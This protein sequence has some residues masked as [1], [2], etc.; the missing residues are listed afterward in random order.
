MARTL[1]SSRGWMQIGTD[2]VSEAI[3]GLDEQEF[4]AESSLPGWN[5]THLVAHLAANADAIGNLIHWAATGEP[6]PMYPSPEARALDIESGS[7]KSGSDLITW[8]QSATSRLEA[9]MSGLTIEEWAHEVVTAQGRTVPASETPWMRSREV[10]V[11]AVDLNVGIDF[12]QLPTDFLAALCQDIVIK[13]T[14][15]AGPAL[16]LHATDAADSWSLPGIG[17]SVRVSGSLAALTGYLSG[18]SSVGLT[19]D[20]GATP[21]SLPAWL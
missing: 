16:T 10:M 7:R 2:L 20:S 14:T 17:A 18:R 19:T 1:E 5:R 13:R 8:F 4:N 9:A 6:T 21:P 12:E 3:A 15:A 11:H